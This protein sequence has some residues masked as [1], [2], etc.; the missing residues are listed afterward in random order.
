VT[1]TYNEIGNLEELVASVRRQALGLHILVVDDNSPDGTGRLA[2]ELSAQT[3]GE[4]SVLHRPGKQGLAKAYVAG[5]RYALSAGYDVIIQMDADLSHDASYL[6]SM[7]TKL[8]ECDLVLG[9]RYIDGINVVN[10]D[11]KRLVLSKV[12]ARYVQLVTGMRFTDST[13][14]YK[15]WRAEALRSID[16]DGVFSNGYLFQVEMTYKALK[17]G[18]RI[19]EVPIIFYER[20]LGNSKIDLGIIVEALW[21]VIRLRLRS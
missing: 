2:D 15:C 8:D 13:G 5:F 18:F 19:A 16:L 4:V 10:W 3:P 6:S 20:N 17:Q 21:G 7:I 9:S 14:G 11:I 12:A 1:P